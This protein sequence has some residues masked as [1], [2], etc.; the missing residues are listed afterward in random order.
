[1]TL[2]I[3][4]VKRYTVP[5]YPR[6]HYRRSKQTAAERL[7]RGGVSTFLLLALQEACDGGGVTGPPPVEPDMVTENEARQ[8]IKQLFAEHGVALQEDVQV[9]FNLLNGTPVGF[10]A[11]GY[12]DSLRVGYEYM[13]PD[14]E[15]EY[16]P[17]PSRVALEKGDNAEGAFVKFVDSM[18]KSS[19]YAAILR[20]QIE[21]FIS[22]LKANG[23]I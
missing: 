19:D 16:V 11:D 3:K 8:V 21:A 22:V 9:L 15:R 23:I 20:S 14:W 7:A 17:E 2:K 6:E 5:K 12:N 18:E 13:N 10:V 1:M 4:R